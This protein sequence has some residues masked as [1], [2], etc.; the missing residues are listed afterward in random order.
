MMIL[1]QNVPFSHR[2]VHPATNV[3]VATFDT[4]PARRTPKRVCACINRVGQDVVHDI[5]GRQSPH[6]A[7]CLP[8][9]RFRRQLYSLVSEP[10]VHLPRALQFGKLR[11]DELQG[12]LHAL[13]WIFSIRSRPTFT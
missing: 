12:L 10:N 3:L 8:L 4:H 2:A 11:E 6:D 13:I 5:V 7:M 9:A 1:D